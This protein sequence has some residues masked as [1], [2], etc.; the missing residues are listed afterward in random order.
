MRITLAQWRD[1]YGL[2][3]EEGDPE[4]GAC[5]A[6]QWTKNDQ[7]PYSLCS[8]HEGFVDGFDAARG[9]G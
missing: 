3:M 8:Y 7:T 2:P 9:G 6:T 5:R 4:C 1:E